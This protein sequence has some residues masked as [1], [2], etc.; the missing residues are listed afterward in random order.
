L[1]EEL[2]KGAY[3]TVYKALNTKNGTTVAIKRIDVENT[4]KEGISSF[5]V[6]ESVN[7]R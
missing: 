7:F 2:G 4:N 6:S 5:M 3:G 1:G